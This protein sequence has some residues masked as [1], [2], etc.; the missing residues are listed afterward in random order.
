M[1]YSFLILSILV[2]PSIQLNI[3]IYAKFFH[4]S[5]WWPDTLFYSIR[6]V[7]SSS[8]KFLNFSAYKFK[9]IR[10]SHVVPVIC[11][12][13]I[14]PT[15]IIFFTF[16]SIS[17]LLYIT[18]LRSWHTEIFSMIHHWKIRRLPGFKIK[19]FSFIF[20]PKFLYKY[21]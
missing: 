19:N 17:P 5:L 11:R 6:Q 2:T 18:V 16:R 4:L 14:H 1:L 7:L 20:I 3:R 10:G 12:H 15:L 8:C 21:I 13:F 9:S